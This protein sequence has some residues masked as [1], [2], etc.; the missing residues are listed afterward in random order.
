MALTLPASGRI[1][2][3]V[4]AS[5]A[6]AVLVV[7]VRRY[8]R[9]AILELRDTRLHT[10][11]W[12]RAR[13]WEIAELG[14]LVTFECKR[15]PIPGVHMAWATAGGVRV[16]FAHA[17]LWPLEEVRALAASAGRGCVELGAVPSFRAARES[18]ACVPRWYLHVYKVSALLGFVLIGGGV[19][20]QEVVFR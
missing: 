16:F 11:G 7:L 8:D 9:Q 20:V 15:G 14:P 6:L 18:G 12:G 13:T 4:A 17:D 19:L 3:V 2:V 10:R 5:I 1:A